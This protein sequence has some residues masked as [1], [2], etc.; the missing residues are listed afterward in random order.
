MKVKTSQRIRTATQAYLE[1]LQLGGEIC[2]ED[3]TSNLIR[4]LLKR[5]IPILTGLSATFLYRTAREI[6]VEDNT[7]YDDIKGEPA[8]H[9]VVLCGYNAEDRMAL[10]ADPLLPNPISESQ[11]YTV[12]L[13]PVNLFHHAWNS[14]L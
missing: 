4:G 14:D 10:V 5:E 3:L 2:F 12:S 7:V 11:I 13:N 9:F 6:D 1:F 8:G